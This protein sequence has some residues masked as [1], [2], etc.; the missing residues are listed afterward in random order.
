M[1]SKTA[2]AASIPAAP[3]WLPKTAYLMLMRNERLAGLRTHYDDDSHV[4]TIRQGRRGRRPGRP[5]DG[6]GPRRHRAFLRREFRQELK[7]PPK[8]LSA[9][10]TAFPT[11]PA[12]WSRSS[13]SPASQPSRT[14]SASPS[15]RCAFAP[16]SMSAA[17]RPGTNSSPLDQTLAI[18]EARLKIVKTDHPLRRRQCRPR[19]RGA[20]PRNPARADAPVRS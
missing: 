3:A 20:R 1:P 2:P 16:T 5:R 9:A 14:W 19:H 4:L 12:R 18:G 15:I 13:I 10:A 11:S 7:G 17:G 6:G 8:L